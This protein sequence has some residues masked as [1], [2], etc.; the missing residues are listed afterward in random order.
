MLI[1]SDYA[2]NSKLILYSY[3]IKTFKTD[4]TTLYL[5]VHISKIL[6]NKCLAT[7]CELNDILS[8]INREFDNYNLTSYGRIRLTIF[9]SLEDG[10]INEDNT[11]VF[12]KIINLCNPVLFFLSNPGSYYTDC[13]LNQVNNTAFLEK[14]STYA[15]QCKGLCELLENRVNCIV[16]SGEDSE[17]YKV[18]IECLENDKVVDNLNQSIPVQ[19]VSGKVNEMARIRDNQF[20]KN[21]IK[22]VKSK[23]SQWFRKLKSKW[24][25]VLEDS[26]EKAIEVTIDEILDIHMSYKS[27]NKEQLIAYQNVLSESNNTSRSICSFLIQNGVRMCDQLKAKTDEDIEN[28]ILKICDLLRLLGKKYIFSNRIFNDENFIKLLVKML[29]CVSKRLITQSTKLI[30]LMMQSN[31]KRYGAAL[32]AFD[33]VYFGSNK[34]TS[35]PKLLFDLINAHA[36]QVT[37]YYTSKETLTNKEDGKDLIDLKWF[38]SNFEFNAL[39]N[40]LKGS[41]ENCRKLSS[42]DFDALIDI[43]IEKTLSK[44][45]Q[46]IKF[47]LFEVLIMIVRYGLNE[48]FAKLLWNRIL[49]I[50]R[51]LNVHLFNLTRVGQIDWAWT[52][53]SNAHKE[54][55]DFVQFYTEFSPKIDQDEKDES[56]FIGDESKCEETSFTIDTELAA[57]S[58]SKIPDFIETSYQSAISTNQ[59]LKS[60]RW[61]RFLQNKQQLTSVCCENESLKSKIESLE[62]NLSDSKTKEGQYLS[63][64]SSLEADRDSRKDECSKLREQLSLLKSSKQTEICTTKINSNEKNVQTANMSS[65]KICFFSNFLAAC[66]LICFNKKEHDDDEASRFIN[67]LRKKNVCQSR[68]EARKYIEAIADKRK[69]LCDF[70]ELICGALKHLSADLYTSPMHFLSEIIQNFEDNQYASNESPF[71]KIILNAEYLIFCSNE[72]NIVDE[73]ITL[74]I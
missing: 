55:L 38:T 19:V 16:L 25:N 4:K 51:E 29:E 44:I 39:C 6:K 10:L 46:H 15:E 59:N 17:S 37:S 14:W 53:L 8:P 18:A 34:S 32:I 33:K 71:L 52:N 45:Q 40:V 60:V 43:L 12:K 57:S 36:Q 11:N 31:H 5:R 70:R 30:N 67:E 21:S 47:H 63:K 26:D 41:P 9:F 28:R 65:N 42:H 72:V 69:N 74:K 64:I 24:A 27:W 58:A 23:F 2:K 20:I 56:E 50:L 7:Q 1:S 61:F 54:L 3:I 22:E 35:C 13:I 73:L 66:N 62:R 68:E 49:P 48:E